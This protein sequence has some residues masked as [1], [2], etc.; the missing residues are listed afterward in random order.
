MDRGEIKILPKEKWPRLLKEINDP[1]EKL[2]IRGTLP[3]DD[4]KWLCVIGSR[5]FTPYGRDACETILEGLRGQKVVIV[6]GLALG[7][8]SLSHRKALEI[9]LNTVAVPGSG[10]NDKV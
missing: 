6:S 9:S 5:K 7:I 2:Y 8:D 1:P 10:L 4:Y 3:P